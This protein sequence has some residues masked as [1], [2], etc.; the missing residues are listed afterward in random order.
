MNIRQANEKDIPE[1]EALYK[2]RVL[3]NDAHGMHQWDLED[4]T[5]I[6]LSKSYCMN[7]FYIL[8]DPEIKACCCIVD[9]DP[10]YWPHKAQGESL[11]LHKIITDPDARKRGYGDLLVSYFKQKGQA[12]GYP[13]VRLDV[14]A[15]KDKLRTFYERNGFQ[16]VEE[17]AIFKDYVTALYA[18]KYK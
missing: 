10:V 15:H 17:K 13:D 11:Y 6:S 8:E 16:L 2:K 9:V 4:V 5:W 7:D 1:I 14:R 12:E 3:Y 18:Y